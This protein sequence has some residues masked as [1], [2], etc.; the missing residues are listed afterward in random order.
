MAIDVKALIADALLRLCEKKTLDTI[1]VKDILTE[2]GVSRQAFYNHFRDKYDLINWIYY[3]YIM[4]NF[5]DVD[6][7]EEIYDRLIHYF[8]NI[9]RY[10]SFMKQALMINGQNCLR[11][12]MTECMKEWDLSWHLHWFAKEGEAAEPVSEKLKFSVW[13][14]SLGNVSVI[15]NW[16]M[17]DM[18]VS[19]EEMAQWIMEVKYYRVYEFMKEPSE[20]TEA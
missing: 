4:D 1:K 16:V 6:I 14:H 18:P 17:D 5:H 9:K 19:V 13:Y 20:Q 15:I 8:S 2:S 10:H 11:D 12:Y 3:T 7:K